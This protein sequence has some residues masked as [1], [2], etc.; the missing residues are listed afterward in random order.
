[1]ELEKLSLY[2]GT[3]STICR[4]MWIRIP[5]R[6]IADS[7]PD[8]GSASASRRIRIQ[9]VKIGLKEFFY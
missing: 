5:V 4:V 7:D 6:C 3:D 1:M 8:N 9:E 2:T